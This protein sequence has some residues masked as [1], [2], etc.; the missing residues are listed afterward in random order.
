MS[1]SPSRRPPS[2]TNAPA[3]VR[4]RSGLVP[5]WALKHCAARWETHGYSRGTLGYCSALLLWPGRGPRVRWSCTQVGTCP[6]PRAATRARRAPCGS[7]PRRRAAPPPPPRARLLGRLPWT[8]TTR[9][10]ATSGPPTTVRTSTPTRSAPATLPP[11]CCAPPSPPVRR[12]TAPQF[13]RVCT[14]R[15]SRASRAVCMI[16]KQMAEI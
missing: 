7:R 10:A 6:V 5:L 12:R 2:V 3:F 11:G 16:I 1:R 8:P 4:V 14:A 15:Y 13:A 9:G